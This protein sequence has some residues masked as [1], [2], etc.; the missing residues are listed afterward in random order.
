MN[1]DLLD[2]SSVSASLGGDISLIQATGGNT[3]VKVDD[4]LW[5]KAS[6][7][8]LKDAL[9]KDIFLPVKL[10]ELRQIMEH[11]DPGEDLSRFVHNGNLRPSIET[12]F[13]ALL[14]KKYIL[15]VHSIKSIA[16]T[17]QKIELRS[18]FSDLNVCFIP[19]VRPGFPLTKKIREISTT[20]EIYILE[21][22]GL[23]VQ[24]DTLEHCLDL[25]T[26]SEKRFNKVVFESQHSDIL[27]HDLSL[28]KILTNPLN[29]KTHQIAFRAQLLGKLK[30]SVFYP[31]Q[32]V[33]LGPEL[34][35][36][37]SI[38][39]AQT[40][41]I[42]YEAKHKFTPHYV[43]IPKIGVF[44]KSPA[45]DGIEEMLL[46]HSLLFNMINSVDSLKE[47]SNK[48]VGEILNWDAEHYRQSLCK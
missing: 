20:A 8:R 35:V 44:L 29:P 15:H 37:E 48:E 27:Q 14:P 34:C 26:E 47:L 42:A 5:V 16:A 11:S 25:I 24:G 9:T 13:H 19:Y 40:E 23:I 12:T 17:I 41:M 31:D 7:M 39:N 30:S 43:I 3:S 38:E 32:A 21:G 10:N 6:G 2:L 18:L 36:S 1:K 45:R 22:H 46:G 4:T 33:F 28:P